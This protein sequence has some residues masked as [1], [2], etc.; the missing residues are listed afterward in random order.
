MTMMGTEKKSL[1]F[2]RKCVKT[3]HRISTRLHGVTP[4]SFSIT[5]T[6][7]S[8]KRGGGLALSPWRQK[9]LACW[10]F[11]IK[12]S[13]T[14]L[15]TFF[16]FCRFKIE[17]GCYVFIFLHKVPLEQRK[18]ESNTRSEENYLLKLVFSSFFYAVKSVGF[19]SCFNSCR[20]G[21]VQ[22]MILERVVFPV[23]WALKYV[24]LFL[25]Y[26]TM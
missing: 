19:I 22:T 4:P 2:W 25:P 17:W 9:I 10:A 5:S 24:C 15:G 11:P 16:P 21:M 26:R 20:W 14:I 23:F 7:W 13:F 12:I 8:K 6:K 3:I 18:K 1:S